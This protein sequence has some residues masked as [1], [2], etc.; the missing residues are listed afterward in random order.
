[1]NATTTGT[2]N[3]AIGGGSLA[4]NVS[5][6]NNVAI[7]KNA[8]GDD[9]VQY[10]GNNTSIGVGF[11]AGNPSPTSATNP[12]FNG[13]VGGVYVGHQAFADFSIDENSTSIE[14]NTVIGRR[15]FRNA[16]LGGEKRLK[17]FEKN[18]II[19]DN[20]A[21]NLDTTV[22]INDAPF[23]VGENIYIGR[24]AGANND[25]G[26]NSVITGNVIIGKLFG[27]SHDIGNIVI[28]AG[29][30]GDKTNTL[31][32]AGATAQD[33]TIVRNNIVLGSN[34]KIFG[35]NNIAINMYSD[36]QPSD[37]SQVQI[38]QLQAGGTA[39]P[40]TENVV[41]GSYAIKI[42]EGTAEFANKNTIINSQAVEI[43]ADGTSNSVNNL[44]LNTFGSSPVDPTIIKGRNNT[45]LNASTFATGGQPLE[46]DYNFVVGASD[47]AIAGIESDNNVIIGSSSTTMVSANDTPITGNVV[48]NGRVVSLT[49]TVAASDSNNTRNNYILGCR[50]IEMTDSGRNFI[51]A[52]EFSSPTSF[53]NLNHNFLFGITS[54]N[55]AQQS[56]ISSG[57]DYNFLFNADDVTLSGANNVV[58]GQMIATITGDKHTILNSSGEV[59]GTGN[60]LLSGTSH[61]VSGNYNVLS[62]SGLETGNST[63]RSLNVGNNNTIGVTGA[64]NN[65]VA[66]GNNIKISDKANN[67]AFGNGI[68]VT[69]STNSTTVGKNNDDSVVNTQGNPCFQVGVG[70]NTTAR[71]NALNI[72]NTTGPLFGVIYMDQ[73]VNQEYAN[74]VDAAAAGIGLGGLYHTNGVVKINLTP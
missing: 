56:S 28:S 11:S 16:G 59:G 23:I 66:I 3:I 42:L 6:Y 30:T 70:Q 51:F 25:P 52:N 9:T 40:T 44:L 65:N 35:N 34:N 60:V 39:Y 31:G 43:N 19:G 12:N 15:A 45:L 61:I 63:A 36:G 69:N 18:T 14:G 7:S 33:S 29:S 1:L 37:P 4:F 55:G 8:L 47:T 22:T 58:F 50:N 49:N 68:S 2:N 71:K 13:H 67:A 32:V 53:Q 5:G 62:G 74:D 20:A 38:G 21:I 10:S 27:G 41:L 26:S 57:S 46:G 54:F 73:L 17:S 24:N 72:V 48:V 64:A